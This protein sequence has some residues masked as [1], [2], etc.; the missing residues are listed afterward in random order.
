[1]LEVTDQTFEQEVKNSDK[2]VVVDFW[3]AWCGPCK[4]VAPI[5]ARLSEQMT[6]VKFVKVDTDTNF[7]TAKLLGIK[8]I[9]TFVVYK[10]GNVTA[11]KSG[12]MSEA[13]LKM[14]IETNK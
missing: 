10:D 14:F 9:P 7:E 12:A 1:M 8:G 2:P 11:T 13:Q 4:A 6:D 5:F 3:A